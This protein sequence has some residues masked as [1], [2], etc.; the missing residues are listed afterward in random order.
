MEKMPYIGQL[1][2]KV[3]IK[4]LAKSQSDTG[5]TK[6]VETLVVRCSASMNEKSG[7]E[8]LDGKV[9]HEVNRSY[10]IRFNTDIV[11]NGKDYILIDAGVKYKINHISEMGRRRFLDLKVS[12]YE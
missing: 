4:K 11:K 12:L 1:D 7:N 2:R 10:I 8:E 3:S 9:M 6:T 5:A